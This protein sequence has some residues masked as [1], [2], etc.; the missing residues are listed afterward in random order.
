MR[1]TQGSPSL[2]LGLMLTA[3]PQLVAAQHPAASMSHE[4]NR[5]SAAPNP[6]TPVTQG[7]PSLALG[8]VLTAAPQ[9]LREARISD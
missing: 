6:W 2:A 4:F 1:V 9:L 5:R 7:S 3:A 8:L